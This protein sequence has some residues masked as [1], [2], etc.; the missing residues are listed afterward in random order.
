M[1]WLSCGIATAIGVPKSR[2]YS[3]TS[4]I[5]TPHSSA[6]KPD[7]A[8]VPPSFD[9][10]LARIEDDVP[11]LGHVVQYGDLSA[12]LNAALATQMQRY[13]NR[14]T[15]YDHTPVERI[16]QLPRADG[17]VAPARVRALQGGPHEGR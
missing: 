1:P 17:T 5:R 16:E 6:N 11:A 10:A 12:A 3:S 15:R 13:P 8:Y 14:L 2:A 4:A 7:P 9:A